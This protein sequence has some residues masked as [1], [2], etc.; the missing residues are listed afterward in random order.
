[1]NTTKL[2]PI[3]LC[4]LFTCSQ[5]ANADTANGGCLFGSTEEGQYVL[6]NVCNWPIHVTFGAG[7]HT[8]IVDIAGR[9]SVNVNG[10]GLISI[11]DVTGR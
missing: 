2:I 6:K 11:I 3:V 4:F 10:I 9:R 7:G 1:M 8:Y 5:S